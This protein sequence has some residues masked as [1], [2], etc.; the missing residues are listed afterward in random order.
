MIDLFLP[1]VIGIGLGIE[2]PAPAE[3]AEAPVVASDDAALALGSGDD[4]G[5]GR[6]PEPQ[7]PTGKFTT[8][9]EVRPILG[10]TK[11]NW[12]GVRDYEG[13]DLIY[14]THLLSWRC[15]LWDIRYGI[16]G[17]AADTVVAM[18]PCNE[19]LAQPN[20]MVDVEN[21]LPYVAYPSGTVQSV[22]VEIVFDDGT[23]DFTRFDRADVALP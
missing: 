23:A 16:N 1:L 2:P 17:A 21:F 6:D 10:M 12:I 15:G 19:D 4:L 11:S 18:E 13:R 9:L 5:A 8:A 20:M 7:T 14:F 22:Y 3:G